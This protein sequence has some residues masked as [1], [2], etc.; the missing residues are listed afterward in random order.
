MGE[1]APQI[2]TMCSLCTQRVLAD[3]IKLNQELV[4][5]GGVLVVS[6]VCAGEYGAGRFGEGSTGGQEGLVGGTESCAAG[7]VAKEAPLERA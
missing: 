1:Y 7:G 5:Q 2:Q 6:E 3:G 4:K